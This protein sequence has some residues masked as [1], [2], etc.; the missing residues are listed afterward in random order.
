V[1]PRFVQSKAAASSKKTAA[2]KT[3]FVVDYSK[4]AAD[5][6]FDAAA[7]EKFLHDRIKVDGKAGQLGESIKIHREGAFVCSRAWASC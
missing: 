1:S 5:G 2:G 3:K 6:L 4:P 7:F